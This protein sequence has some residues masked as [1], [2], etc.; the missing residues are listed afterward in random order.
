[1]VSSSSNSAAASSLRARPSETALPKISGVVESAIPR[2]APLI[3]CV[4]VMERH[5]RLEYHL[6]PGTC[7]DEVHHMAII[8]TLHVSSEHAFSNNVLNHFIVACVQRTLSID[9]EKQQRVLLW[10]ALHRDR[11][12]RRTTSSSHLA[13]NH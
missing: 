1:M 9:A 13:A 5:P 7:N 8:Q 2:L 11:R 12:V 6:A 3:A 4:Q 10:S